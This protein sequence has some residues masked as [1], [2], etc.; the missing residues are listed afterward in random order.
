M[1]TARSLALQCCEA[2]FNFDLEK[3]ELWLRLWTS[4]PE[5]AYARCS[6]NGGGTLS[7]VPVTAVNSVVVQPPS[8][9]AT[10]VQLVGRVVVGNET[11]GSSQHE[12]ATW[13]QHALQSVEAN[14]E[15]DGSLSPRNVVRLLLWQFEH[16]TP[17][18][19][20]QKREELGQFFQYL[21]A[22]EAAL[23]DVVRVEWAARNGICAE[24][25][26]LR[27]KC[28]RE[29]RRSIDI[30]ALQTSLTAGG[31]RTTSTHVNEALADSALQRSGSGRVV[32]EADS[33]VDEITFDAVS[34]M[35]RLVTLHSTTD[36]LHSQIGLLQRYVVDTAAALQRCVEPVCAP[37]VEYAA[38]HATQV[39]ETLQSLETRFS[40]LEDLFRRA[41]LHQRGGAG[42]E[43]SRCQPAAATSHPL[44][45]KP[46]TSATEDERRA[47]STLLHPLDNEL[48]HPSPAA[49]ASTT[50]TPS[51]G[52][53]EVSAVRGAAL[54]A[55]VAL[56]PT[57][58]LCELLLLGVAWLDVAGLKLAD[59]LRC[60]EQE[61]ASCPL[62]HS[63]PLAFTS[64]GVLLNCLFAP[65]DAAKAGRIS[66]SEASYG[67]ATLTSS[68]SAQKA[69]RSCDA[70]AELY[71]DTA[72]Q[73][74]CDVPLLAVADWLRTAW[75]TT[76]D[77]ELLFRIYV[78]CTSVVLHSLRVQGCYPSGVP[79]P[80][81][82][83]LL[84]GVCGA[85]VGNAPSEMENA[86][87]VVWHGLLRYGSPSEQPREVRKASLDVLVQ[88]DSPPVSISW[89]LVLCAVVVMAI[90]E[91]SPVTGTPD[92]CLH[93]LCTSALL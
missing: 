44:P 81:D 40:T 17:P 32:M 67:G 10:T 58:D 56:P 59:F 39:G 9:S 60:C 41:S 6:S 82:S 92:E 21:L 84:D 90:A 4:L 64:S 19:P 89:L 78:Y 73:M 29:V 77:S 16:M 69:L 49:P 11:T 66:D 93:A 35:Q 38:H 27:L 23:I 34:V 15:E 42:D 76:R 31:V 85:A 70:F 7:V 87:A 57:L 20:Q 12:V 75:P 74:E 43:A 62:S 71:S 25:A 72:G 1:A 48:L 54:R 3:E 30:C 50:M 45:R 86:V 14:T 80:T 91:E 13:L 83:S 63:P 52:G 2:A 61:S 51:R 46:H 36:A 53:R 37:V 8:V 47:V 22:L 79:A 24:E 18:P 68:V 5:E 28:T 33:A 55:G 88:L 26:A 65:D